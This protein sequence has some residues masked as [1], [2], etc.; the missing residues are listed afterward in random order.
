MVKPTVAV[1]FTVVMSGVTV[2]NLGGA[3]RAGD[4]GTPGP[5]AADLLPPPPP[6]EKSPWEKVYEAAERVWRQRD[7]VAGRLKGRVLGCLIH[8]GMCLKQVEEILGENPRR[9]TA[10]LDLGAGR[11]SRTDYDPDLG[12]SVM[13]TEQA[14]VS[15]VNRP[16]EFDPLLD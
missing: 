8:K 12:L 5:T 11:I 15:Q 4:G 14:G 6:K 9:L 13:T 7:K 2:A 1:V 10:E 16:V 3:G